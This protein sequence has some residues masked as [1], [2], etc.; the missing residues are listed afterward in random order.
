M[1]CRA[2]TG[3]GQSCFGSARSRSEPT[4]GTEILD[5]TVLALGHSRSILNQRP[6]RESQ[7]PTTAGPVGG[8]PR[9]SGHAGPARRS[10]RPTTGLRDTKPAPCNLPAVGRHT[11]GP[12]QQT[13]QDQEEGTQYTGRPSRPEQG[14]S[15]P[16][17]TPGPLGQS[18]CGPA[19]CCSC[20]LVLL[21]L[22]SDWRPRYTEEKHQS[23]PKGGKRPGIPEVGPGPH[24]RVLPTSA[25]R[26]GL[27]V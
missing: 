11:C 24:G 26:Q 19:T 4:D 27:Q 12:G 7:N 17:H 15:D 9:A 3:E 23:P 6:A 8:V 14:P 1:S 22:A 18:Q 25:P 20:R 16:V 2:L 5:P 10:P 21:S 13:S